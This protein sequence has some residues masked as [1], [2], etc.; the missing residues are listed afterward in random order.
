MTGTAS[1]TQ[2]AALLAQ[3]RRLTEAGPAADPADRAAY[4]AA[5]AALLARITGHP[6]DH[7]DE[8]SR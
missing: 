3:A 4:L 5:K 8:D 1:A 7:T 6:H 2:I